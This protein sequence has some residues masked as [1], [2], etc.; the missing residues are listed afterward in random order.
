MLINMALTF[1]A[2]S[3]SLRTLTWCLPL[4][5]DTALT[6]F[7]TPYSSPARTL[8][9]RGG[10]VPKKAP[11]AC[12]ADHPPTG[13]PLSEE[14]DG[15]VGSRAVVRAVGPTGHGGQCRP[16]PDRPSAYSAPS[17]KEDGRAEP[18][19]RNS[20]DLGVANR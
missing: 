11:P 18:R 4:G 20:G 16:W 9:V 19:P 10:R 2:V 1:R 5:L 7:P 17:E 13:S 3:L 15:R 8:G 6:S 14:C 12:H